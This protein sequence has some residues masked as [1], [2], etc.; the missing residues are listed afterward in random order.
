MLPLFRK[1]HRWIGLATAFFL[2]VSGLT[3]AV[4]SFDHEL[5]ALLNPALYH[6]HSE[7]DGVT[8]VQSPLQLAAQ[9]EAA[10]PRV[11]ITYMPL[12]AEPEHT[13][14]FFVTPRVD[15]GTGALYDLP[16]NQMALDPVSGELQATRMWGAVSLT[17][18]GLLPFL[19]KLHYSMHLP[20]AFGI[21]TGILFMGLIAIAWTLDCF[22]ALWISF[23]SRKRWRRSFQFSFR[24]GSRRAVFDLH[25]SSGVWLWVP[26]LVLAITAVSMNLGDEVVRPV[27]GLFSELSTDPFAERSPTP[28]N[29]PIAPQISRA[30]VIATASAEAQRRGWDAPPGALFYAPNHG[31]YGVG[32]FSPGH[33][34]GDGGLGNPW[35]YFDSADGAPV[36]AVTPGEGSLGDLFMQAQFPLHSGRIA[37]MPGRILVSLLGLVV[38]MLSATGVILWARKR[39]GS[40]RAAR[41]SRAA[42]GSGG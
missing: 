19:Y 34:H 14:M 28:L 25:R 9:V 13:T 10:D 6:A 15:P 24:K 1:L 21:E 11:H 30:E 26:L 2:F 12:A 7:H 37:G 17:R 20:F 27:V 41:R 32:F 38:A 3:G 16:F 23:P 39:V 4:I 29:E 5:D 33:D 35:L 31:V 8:G 40:A 42:Q 36:G 18:Q 22:I